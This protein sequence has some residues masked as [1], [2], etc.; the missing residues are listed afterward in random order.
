LLITTAA[1]TFL[2]TLALGFGYLNYFT[3]FFDKSAIAVS[4]TTKSEEAYTELID[5]TK[6]DENI[7][8]EPEEEKAEVIEE[9]E[10]AVKEEEHNLAEV[11]KPAIKE[12]QPKPVVK[13]KPE[14]QQKVQSVKP[15]TK[16]EEKPVI[17]KKEEKPEIASNTENLSKRTT[18]SDVTE[19]VQNDGQVFIV[20]IYATPS[21]KDAEDWL[22]KLNKKKHRKCFYNVQRK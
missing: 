12:E 10:D 21:K 15:R 8:E 2:I 22:R 3:D 13:K 11:K 5:T 1:A 20:Q 7:E 16:P 4:D 6:I 9:V 18:I 17:T 14:K 19:N